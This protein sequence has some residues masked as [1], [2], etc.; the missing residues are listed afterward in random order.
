[1]NKKLLILTAV[2]LI[3]FALTACRPAKAL[4]S[5]TTRYATQTIKLRNKA[6]GK[7]L[8]KVKRNTA[9]T[10]IG[11]GGKKWI[12]VK[13]KGKRYVTVKKYLNA[14]RCPGKKKAAEYIKYLHTCGPV[15][16]HGRKY[17]YY[18][19]RILPIYKLPVPGL[20]LDSNGMWC[21][22]WDYIVLGSSRANKA[23]R[24]VFATPFGKFG[25]VYDTGTASTPS[26]LCDT[27]TNW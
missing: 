3:I 24:V 20:H 14:E 5:T 4:A 17:T 16:W 12:R 13:Y 1:M 15:T 9:V 26:W 22:K 6:G 8:K 25:K 23:A 19:S 27:A 21:D 18:T 10:I 11:K 7:V 2:A